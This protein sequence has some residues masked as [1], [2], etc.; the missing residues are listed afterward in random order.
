MTYRPMNVKTDCYWKNGDKIQ[1]LQCVKEQ[2]TDEET[3]KECQYNRLRIEQRGEDH[4][5]DS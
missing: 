1:E 3:C 5:S 4:G 2:G